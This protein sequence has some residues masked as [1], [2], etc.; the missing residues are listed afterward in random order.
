MSD[1]ANYRD[2]HTLYVKCNN[3]TPIQ[4]AECFTKAIEEHQK[5]HRVNLACPFRVNF[6]EDKDGK[7]FGFAFVFVRNPAV[8]HMLLGKNPDG[9]DRIEYHDDPSWTDPE[10][11]DN[12]NDAGWSTIS[13]PIYIPGMSWADATEEEDKYQ[14]QIDA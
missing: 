4:I 11:G 13:A 6:V 2:T 8:Y 5:V 1:S 3:A 10:K 12:V 14:Q 9:S 7:P